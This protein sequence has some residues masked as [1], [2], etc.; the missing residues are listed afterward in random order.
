MDRARHRHR[1][2]RVG[3]AGRRQGDDAVDAARRVLRRRRGVRPEEHHLGGGARPRRRDLDRPALPRRG[4]RASARRR[5][6]TCMSQKMGIHEWSYDN[7]I[8]RRQALPRAAQ[9]HGDRAA[10]TSRSRSSS[11]SIPSSPSPRR[12]AASTATCRRCSPTSCASSAMPASTSARWTASRSPPTATKPTCAR[13]C[14]APAP[15][16][17][18]GPL[19][20][21]TAQ[22]RPHHGQGRGR[23]PA[24][25]PVRRA[26]PDRRVGHAEV[27]ARHARRPTI[28]A[29]GIAR[30]S[31][32]AKLAAWRRNRR[33]DDNRSHASTTSSSSSPTSTAPARRRRTGCSRKRSCAWACRSR[34]RN[35]FPS[36]I[37]GLPTWYEVRVVEARLARPARRRRP[38][39]RDE[40][41]DLGQ[42]RRRDRAGRLSVLR[43]DQ[44]AAAR[45]SSATTST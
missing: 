8:T 28:A 44:A 31:A 34:A 27:P 7:A 2:R 45:R 22:D 36:N 10:Q 35:I 23:V 38:D 9:G 16:L 14:S 26:L 19:R 5:T 37:Q 41:A 17:D 30:R 11:A 3:H 4:R 29:A 1:V 32:P 21:R 33:R 18:A 20:L 12:S 25:R 43:L 6:S 24:L 40:P 13:G 42:G 39:G 15:N